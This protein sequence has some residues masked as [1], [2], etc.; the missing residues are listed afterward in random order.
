[1]KKNESLDLVQ[2]ND[3]LQGG[4][5]SLSTD[6]MNKIKGGANTNVTSCKNTG[7]CTTT[8]SGTCTNYSGCS[9]A[10]NTG[11]CYNK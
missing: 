5:M 3:Q 8:N 6:K 10:T 4:F 1:M 11:T 9:G 2:K 7:S